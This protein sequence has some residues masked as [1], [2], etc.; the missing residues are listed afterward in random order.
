MFC[1][2][3]DVNR[4]WKS[5]HE[6]LVTSS[7]TAV[8]TKFSDD[9]N[10]ESSNDFSVQKI[11]QNESEIEY[12][13]SKSTKKIKF[14]NERLIA[15]LDK[16]GVTERNAMYLISTVAFALGHDLDELVIRDTIRRAR[17]NTRANVAQRV[18]QQVS[19]TWFSILI[20]IKIEVIDNR[21]M[22]LAVQFNFNSLLLLFNVIKQFIKKS[23]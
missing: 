23:S 6:K 18:K 5:P 4:P 13:V 15:A 21:F 10:T 16:C 17:K 8:P 19:V 7:A 1:K 20:N 2:E 22:R 11:E 3:N 14:I 12:K 9:S